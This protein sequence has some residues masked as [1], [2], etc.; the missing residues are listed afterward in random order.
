M[1]AAQFALEI[2][3]DLERTDDIFRTEIRVIGLEALKR[4]VLKTPVDN[5]FARN[6]WFVEFGEAGVSDTE[7]PDSSGELAISRGASKIAEYAT[8]EGFPIISLYSNLV[9]IQELET[10]HSSQAPSGMVAVTAAEL[11]ASL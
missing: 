7:Q 10:G 1:S 9:Y 8:M 3:R 5:G 2:D 11:Q 6:S 4:V